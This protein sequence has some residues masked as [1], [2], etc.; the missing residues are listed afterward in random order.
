MVISAKQSLDLK[1]LEQEVDRL[2][3]FESQY[4]VLERKL[5]K[6]RRINDELE[7]KIASKSEV[8]DLIAFLNTS[9]KT[10]EEELGFN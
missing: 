1:N 4:Q 10:L 6:Q 9:N 3:I 8:E 7:V 5:R 2:T